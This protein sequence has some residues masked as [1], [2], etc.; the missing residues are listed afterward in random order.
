MRAHRDHQPAPAGQPRA[1]LLAVLF[2]A[3]CLLWFASLGTRAL[4]TPD[5]GRYATLA[6]E[7]ARSGDWV[8]P[9]LNG[10]L[11]FE[12]PAFQY[13]IGGIAFRLFGVSE[14]TARL[15]PGTA[16]FLSLLAVAFT[17]WR[18][19]GRQAGIRAF[20]VAA[21]T[22]WIAANS[23]FLSLDTGLML[24]LTLVLCAVLLADGDAAIDPQVRRRWIWLAWAAMAGAV[25]SKGLVGVVIPAAVLAIVSVWRRDAGL[26]RGMHWGS[27]L[28]IFAALTAPWFVL[29][30]LRN[31][32]FA[33]F[34]FIHEHFA[35]YTSEVHRRT[36]AWWYFVPIL[37]GGML[38]WT[39]ALPWLGRAAGSA[40]G[41][42][43]VGNQD[44]LV[45]WCAFVFVFF[46]AS[47]SK[48]PSYILPMFPALALLV[49]A[50]LQDAS[51]A[52]LGRHLAG[53]AVLW[54]LLLLASTQFARF[55][56]SGDARELLAPMAWAVR[57]G[58]VVFLAAA[59]VAAWQLR[60]GGAT[61]AVLAVAAGHLLAITLVMQSHDAYGRRLKSAAPLAASVRREIGA[62]DPVFA[63][64]SYDQTLPFYLA[65]HVVLV[66]YRDEFALGQSIEP[67]RWIPTLDAFVDRWQSLPQ[68]AAYMNRATWQV[69]R[70]R[71]VPMRAIFEDSRRVVVVRR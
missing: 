44:I 45:A 49:T 50:R 26:V 41:G 51:P 28:L 43:R 22:T 19:W 34:F 68:A 38:P 46:S 12:K 33:R 40:P 27:G 15:W 65:R 17:A 7:M 25:L 54:G 31:P 36:G 35:R 39:G 53:L 23:H 20:A 56:A 58:A 4:I 60:R 29:V 57:A 2:L 52:A 48:L 37:L 16:G 64:R 63:V 8:T 71:G 30:S 61:A 6:W 32:E 5:E 62:D 14:F 3:V 9:R 24:F 1:A 70:Q 67:G 59:A 18:L 13:W 55:T 66:D 69:L 47:G 10:L 21:S 42:T 11:Y